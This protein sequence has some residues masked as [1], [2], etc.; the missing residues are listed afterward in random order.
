MVDTLY[1]NHRLSKQEPCFGEENFLVNSVF[2]EEHK[3]EVTLFG[4]TSQ[5]KERHGQ[6][7]G[8]STEV[9]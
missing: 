4:I 7:C 5:W 9:S 2:H 8:P 1:D 6:H 3:V